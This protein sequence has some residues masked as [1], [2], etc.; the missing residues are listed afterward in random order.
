MYL[1]VPFHEKRVA[2]GLGAQFDTSR[3]RWF[4][5]QDVALAHQDQAA[6]ASTPLL[7]TSYY[8]APYALPLTTPLETVLL[9]TTLTLTTS[10]LLTSY[11]I[12]LTAPHY[13][14]LYTEQGPFCA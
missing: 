4:V 3:R 9:G 7:Y 5:M 13:C 2:I 8:T 10:C 11:A 1:H 6:A 12:P 14:A